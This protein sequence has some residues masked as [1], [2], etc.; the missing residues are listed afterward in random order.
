MIAKEVRSG[1]VW[2]L[3]RGEFGS[4]PPY[5]IGPDTLLIGY[6]IS[7]EVGCY[8]ALNWPVPLRVLD[9]FTEFRCLTRIIHQL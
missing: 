5:P 9:L 6:Y 1:R 4:K 8:L 7:A 2:R 3:W